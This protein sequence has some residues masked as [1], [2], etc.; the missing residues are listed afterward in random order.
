MQIDRETVKSQATLRGKGGGAG[1]RER[2]W[3]R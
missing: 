1:W 3:G 2:G